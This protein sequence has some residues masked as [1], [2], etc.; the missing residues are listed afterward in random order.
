MVME[1]EGEGI[2]Q[3][4]CQATGTPGRAAVRPE[5]GQ[6]DNPFARQHICQTTHLPDNPFNGT[7]SL[8]L[9]LLLMTAPS[10]PQRAS[11]GRDRY[12]CPLRFALV[13]CARR[14]CGDGVENPSCRLGS[15]AV[16]AGAAPA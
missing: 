9:R 12:A 5:A 1:F 7:R 11:C 15:V 10:L 2:G 3:C 6:R 14:C 4:P 16:A 13:I 8:A